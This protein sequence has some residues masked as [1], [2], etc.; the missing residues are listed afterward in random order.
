MAMAKPCHGCERVTSFICIAQYYNGEH[1]GLIC[2]T[3]FDEGYRCWLL[4]DGSLEVSVHQPPN[5]KPAQ[6][7]W[8]EG[9]HAT[10]GKDGMPIYPK[11]DQPA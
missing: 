9:F 8:D 10:G 6:L 4:E 7:Y 1:E 5:S 3:C 2:P 11:I